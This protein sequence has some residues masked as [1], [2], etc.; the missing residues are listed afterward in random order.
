[1][2]ELSRIVAEAMREGPQ[3]G[4]YKCQYCGQAYTRETSLAA[5]QCEPKRRAQQ[6]TE[7]GVQL[8]YQAWIRF[9]EVTQGSAK[10][11]TY[12]DFARNQ[13]YGAFVKFGRHC[14][15]ISAIN[16]GRFIDYVLKNN[17]KI[18]HWCYDKHYDRYLF[19][20]L[21]SEAAQD[22]LDRGIKHM[23]DWS[24][25]T[26]EQWNDYFRKV[27]GPRLTSNLMNGRISPWLLYNCDSGIEALSR[28]SEDEVTRVWVWIDPDFWEKRLRDYVADAE[29]AK[30]I[31]SEAGI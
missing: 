20:L 7:V 9:H 22:A 24:E 23:V 1:M 31:L 25:E 13:F 10:T 27:S 8:G 11:K 19:E 3:Q 28:L 4:Q 21:R 30:H 14:H 5:H 17:I 18:D 26:N 29:L 6:K 16:A 12:E 2:S 15:S